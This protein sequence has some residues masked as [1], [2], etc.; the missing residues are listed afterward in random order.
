MVMTN[1]HFSFGGLKLMLLSRSVSNIEM[2]RDNNQ[3][4]AVIL[5]SA[6]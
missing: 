5:S 6:Y 4:F 2:K 1:K 3:D